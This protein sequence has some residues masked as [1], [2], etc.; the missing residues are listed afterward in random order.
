M[1]MKALGRN[2][3]SKVNENKIWWRY[4]LNSSLPNLA[5]FIIFLVSFD[6]HSNFINM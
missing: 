1:L 6:I 5:I 2:L 4:F 3:F